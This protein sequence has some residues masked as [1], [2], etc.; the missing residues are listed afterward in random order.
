M[1]NNVLSLNTLQHINCD[2]NYLHLFTFEQ[3]KIFKTYRPEV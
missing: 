2:Q 3:K 1:F